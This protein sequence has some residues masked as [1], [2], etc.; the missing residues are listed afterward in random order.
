MCFYRN[1][2]TKCSE[3]RVKGLSTSSN[4]TNW[5]HPL[6]TSGFLASEIHFWNSTKGILKEKYS[7]LAHS[8]SLKYML[9]IRSVVRS[10]RWPA[11]FM[12]IRKHPVCLP[13]R[14][15][16]HTALP[17]HS[18]VGVLV[19]SSRRQTP[20]SLRSWH[21]TA[22]QLTR[23]NC[24]HHHL[25]GHLEKSFPTLLRAPTNSHTNPLHR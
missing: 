20:S 6:V 14:Q 4:Y 19:G 3:K 18:S 10:T 2:N 13:H 23:A 21:P 24:R 22:C 9:E 1:R 7:F 17:L 5:P 12:L 16:P 8:L 25:Y 15:V 11:E